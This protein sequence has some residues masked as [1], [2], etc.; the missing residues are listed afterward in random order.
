MV[1]INGPAPGG[2]I[3]LNNTNYATEGNIVGPS[4]VF[5][6]GDVVDADPRIISNLIVDQSSVNAAAVAAYN[7]LRPEGSPLQTV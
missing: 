2:V 6:S 3:V 1:D 4:G 7:A 5:V